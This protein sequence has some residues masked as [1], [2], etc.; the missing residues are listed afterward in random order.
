MC[1]QVTF[2]LDTVALI[3]LNRAQVL[4]RLITSFNCVVTREVKYEAVDKA[5]A[6]NHQDAYEIELH[7]AEC[8]LAEDLPIQS[9]SKPGLGDGD[10]S[11]LLFMEI[12]ASELTNPGLRVVTDDLRLKRE[13][14]SK[15][16]ECFRSKA[17]ITKL[18]AGGN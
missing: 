14:E 18:L 13:L 1:Q 8:V 10:L 15:G 7:I 5:K 6:N 16:V 11:I 12:I 2:V 3:H 17:I 9:G 4:E